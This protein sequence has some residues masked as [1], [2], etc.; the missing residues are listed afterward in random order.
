MWIYK[1]KQTSCFFASA[2]SVWARCFWFSS[3]LPMSTRMDFVLAAALR[4]FLSFVFFVTRLRDEED[5]A[6]AT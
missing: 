3:K 2:K 5:Q 6:I 4:K 1:L